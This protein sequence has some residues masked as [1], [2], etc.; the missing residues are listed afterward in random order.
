MRSPFPILALIALLSI[1]GE[2]GARELVP[3][4]F[5]LPQT[6]RFTKCID[7]KIASCTRSR[8]VKCK[9]HENC[10]LTGQICDLPFLL[11]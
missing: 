11:R 9:S 7:G 1:Y 10:A 8:N 4:R 3:A 2:A 5:C 6:S